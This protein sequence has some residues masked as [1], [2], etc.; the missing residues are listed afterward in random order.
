MLKGGE[1]FPG[2]IDCDTLEKLYDVPF[3]EYR[4]GKDVVYISGNVTN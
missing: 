3:K 4:N 2:Q 1:I